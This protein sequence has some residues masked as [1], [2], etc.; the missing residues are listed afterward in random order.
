MIGSGGA[1][2]RLVLSMAVAL[3]SAGCAEV[4]SGRL[5]VTSGFTDQVFV[6]DAATGEVLDSLWLD[7]RPGERDEP[8]G[9]A[10]SPDGQHFY[11][12]LSHGEP[13]LWKYESEGLRLVGRVTLPTSGAAR[14][15]LSPD[16]EM[17]AV[18]DYWLSGGGVN[19][20]VAFVNTRD[21]TIHASPEVCPAPHD[22]SYSPDGAFIAVTCAAGD[23]LVI[24]DAADL[25]D[26]QR[27]STE[28]GAKPMNVAWR[29]NSR[30]FLT[31]GA[32]PHVVDVDLNNPGS[33]TLLSTDDGGAQI[34]VGRDR[35]VIANRGAGTVSIVDLLRG[36]TR[37][38]VIPGANPHGVA[39]S[40]GRSIAYVTYEGDTRSR[41][42]VVAVDLASG[43]IVWHTDVGVFTLGVAVLPE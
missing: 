17:A 43:D 10:V 23:Q 18:P 37:S 12:T 28:A 31:L 4:P 6:L 5:L 7:P 38:V 25:S 3:V 21:L 22:A 35:A 19:S 40:P 15:R 34:E 11:V 30:L 2:H 14:V 13:T 29:D 33:R 42:G 32:A 26:F 20:R 9:I 36:G 8:H 16:G 41:G 1:L 39:L 24:L 27:L